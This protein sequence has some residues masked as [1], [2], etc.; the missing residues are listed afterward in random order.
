[1]SDS[2]TKEFLETG[3]IRHEVIGD[4]KYEKV[5]KWSDQDTLPMGE[6]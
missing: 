1:M 2:G 6:F 3:E 5:N 4:I